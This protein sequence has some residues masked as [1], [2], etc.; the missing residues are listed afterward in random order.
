MATAAREAMLE[1]TAIILILLSLAGRFGAFG[2]LGAFGERT[3]P[4]LL[5]VAGLVLLLARAALGRR[6]TPNP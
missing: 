1:K 6:P 5:L 3:L 4:G 2:A